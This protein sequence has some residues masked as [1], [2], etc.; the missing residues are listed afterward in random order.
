MKYN[1]GSW[2]ED[3]L[4]GIGS[5]V[6][7]ATS[8]TRLDTHGKAAYIKSINKYIICLNAQSAHDFHLYTSADGINWEMKR[9]FNNGMREC[10]RMGHLQELVTLQKTVMNWEMSFMSTGRTKR[11]ITATTPI[12]EVELLSKGRPFPA[13]LCLSGRITTDEQDV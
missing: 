1:N 7:R 8:G 5:E 10:V 4:T 13:V 9:Y 2:N 11:A 12:I 6:I 3:G